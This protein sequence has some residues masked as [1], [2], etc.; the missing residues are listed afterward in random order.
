VPRVSSALTSLTIN[1]NMSNRTCTSADVGATACDAM[2]AAAADGKMRLPGVPV[3]CTVTSTEE[4][5]NTT[6][7]QRIRNTCLERKECYAHKAAAD[8]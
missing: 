7:S 6:I 4:R 8:T 1:V 3:I 2:F 5:Q